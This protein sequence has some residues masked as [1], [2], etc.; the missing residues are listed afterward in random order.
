MLCTMRSASSGARA[1][2]ASAVAL[3]PLGLLVLWWAF[4]DGGYDPVDWEPGA[5]VALVLAAF[6]VA[7][8]GLRLARRPTRAALVALAALALYTA[9]SYA[10][11]AWAGAPGT[12][13][14]GA[15]RCL[16]LLAV[17]TVAVL[18]APPPAVL[19][20]ASLVVAGVIGAAAVWTALRLERADTAAGLFLDG[21]LL[22]PMGYVNATAAFFTT[23][24]LLGT[25]LAARRDTPVVLRPALVGL[26]V[27]ELGLA[28][29]T[30]SRGWLFTLPVVLVACLALTGGRLRATAAAA[31][32]G[33]ALLPVVDRL[34][35]PTRAGGG[36]KRPEEGGPLA[37]AAAQDA[38]GPLGLAVAVAVLLGAL[39]VALERRVRVGERA[40]R[41]AARAAGVAAVVVAVAATGI[42][43]AVVSDPAGRV[44]RAWQ[45][46]KANDLSEQTGEG[47][48]TATGSSRYDFWRV[49]VDLAERR[50][51]A[52]IGQDNFAQPYLAR[53]AVDNEEPRWVH[54]L[55]LRAVVHTGLVGALLLAVAL[56]GLVAAGVRQRGAPGDERGL[57][58]VAL[59][60]LVVWALHGSVDWLWEFPLLSVLALGLAAA[61]GSRPAGEGP[62]ALGW[63]R[64]RRAR[65]VLTGGVIALAALGAVAV[66][67]DYVAQRDVRAASRGWPSD[68]AGAFER[69]DQAR[70]LTPSARPAI[71]EGVIAQ[72]VGDP[73]RAEAAFAE[74][75]DREPDDWFARFQLGL[76]RGAAGDRTGAR[77]LFEEAARRNPKE[78]V[79]RAARAALARGGT[80]T[81]RDA[82][83]LL[84]ERA[85]SRFGT[86]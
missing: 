1:A 80:F 33:V 9:W 12:A 37:L 39:A 84:A 40:A 72:R 3:L 83:R 8:P 10:S 4:D 51:L 6:V 22:A 36:G 23:G 82:E 28:L 76:A 67:A 16:L 62:A 55:P 52:G 20:G 14:E 30:S 77:R 2:T 34:L 17:V 32:V 71:V 7:S 19:R 46:F 81:V 70:D 57:A 43:L 44:D 68:P 73:R 35:E 60:P 26:A 64:S 49:A 79:I 50:P 85:R 41:R 63:V 15:H 27:L 42:G 25:L 61:A 56:G 58:G 29:M 31:I 69:L 13:L 5:V 65:Q 21:R 86:P 75:A 45:E 11:V 66:L 47:R 78:P 74:A 24:A 38:L 48:L 53:R 54:S 18:A 59:V